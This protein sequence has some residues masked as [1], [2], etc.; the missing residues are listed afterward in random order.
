MNFNQ[1]VL[2]FDQ[3]EKPMKIQWKNNGLYCEGRLIR[4]KDF[5]LFV[6]QEAEEK[7]RIPSFLGHGAKLHLADGTFMVVA[8]PIGPVAMPDKEL[9][10]IVSHFP[11]VYNFMGVTDHID[12]YNIIHP[13]GSGE[14]QQVYMM[15]DS[16]IIKELIAKY[17]VYPPGTWVMKHFAS[18]Y[19][20]GIERPDMMITA[21]TSLNKVSFSLKKVKPSYCF[22]QFKP[23]TP[24]I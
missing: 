20:G 13:D 4:S 21:E 24:M 3:Q 18:R 16:V 12:Y 22:Q 14:V 17:E 9:T 7:Q 2:P 10:P 23:F 19:R 11:N 5:P 15:K 8:T 6:K 1:G